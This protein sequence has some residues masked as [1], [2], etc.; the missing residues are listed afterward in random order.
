[1]MAGMRRRRTDNNSLILWPSVEKRKDGIRRDAFLFPL[2]FRASCS[3][4]V[5]VFCSVCVCVCVG[6]AGVQS[7]SPHG[8][9]GLHPKPV[10][11]CLSITCT[12]T[13]LYCI[14]CMCW[15]AILAFVYIFIYLFILAP[16]C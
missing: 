12:A 15:H 5:N 2:P 6:H 10:C 9:V 4:W 14:A 13:W 16:L 11:V 3:W 7:V 8:F 1:M